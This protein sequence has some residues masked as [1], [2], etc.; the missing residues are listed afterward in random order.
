MPEPAN[1]R[2]CWFHARDYGLLVA[3]PFG[4]KAFTRGEASRVVVKPGEEFRLR[5]GVEA[6][7]VPADKTPDAAAAYREYLKR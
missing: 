2:P 4:R 3:N 1:F 5:F 6:Y 7:A